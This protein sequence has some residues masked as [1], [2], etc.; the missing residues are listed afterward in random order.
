MSKFFDRRFEIIINNDVF[1]EAMAGRQFKI[2]FNVVHDFGGFNSF[3]DLSIYNLTPSTSLKAFQR[4]GEIILKAGYSDNYDVIFKGSI[5]NILRESAYPG[6][7][8]RLICVGG[9][10]EGKSINQTLG[11]KASVVM[12]IE[13]I[14]T[15]LGYPLV[16]N[17]NDFSGLNFPRGKTLNG[18]PRVLLDSLAN[19]YEFKYVIENNKIVIVKDGSVRESGARI[20]SQFTGMEGIPEITEIGV[21]VVTRLEPQLKIG[22]VVQ[23]ESQFKTFNFSNIYFQDVKNSD[24]TGT[25][26]ILKITH[27]GDSYGDSWSTSVSGLLI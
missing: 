3:C 8:T 4:G 24:G 6:V 21:D 18:D 14:A 10:I 26:K 16:I 1:I 22:G 12:A 7:L 27:S 19:D 25:Y 5:K 20:I 9:T 13:H 2:E 11:V 15:E 23:V 17:K